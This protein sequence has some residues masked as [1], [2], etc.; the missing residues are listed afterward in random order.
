MQHVHLMS[1]QAFIKFAGRPLNTHTI[2]RVIRAN[3]RSLPE[4]NLLVSAHALFVMQCELI[5]NSVLL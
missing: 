4:E 3:Y 2:I 5:D 1:K